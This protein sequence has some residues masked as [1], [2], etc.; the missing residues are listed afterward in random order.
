[1]KQTTTF[2]VFSVLVSALFLTACDRKESTHTPFK[3]TDITGAPY[4]KGWTLTDHTGTQRTLSDYKGKVVTVFFGYTQCPDVCPITLHDM[5]QVKQQLGADGERLQVVF[6][7]VDPERDTQAVLAEY[8]PGFDASF[9]GLRG[10]PEATAAVTKDFKVVAQQVAGPTPTSYTV[11]H[12]AGTYVF[13]PK[14][15]LRLFIRYGA[16]I[17]EIVT[18]L[19]RLLSESP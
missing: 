14:G 5:V 18:D 4:A 6:I 15:R 7:T 17:E 1:M 16:P 13:D 19:R 11:N 8:V 3:S 2:W 12:T 10:S 9:V